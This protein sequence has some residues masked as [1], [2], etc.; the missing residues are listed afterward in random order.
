MPT[1][2][3]TPVKF[4]LNFRLVHRRSFFPKIIQGCTLFYHKEEGKKN[5]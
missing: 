5:E 1:E 3:D 2:A 4:L